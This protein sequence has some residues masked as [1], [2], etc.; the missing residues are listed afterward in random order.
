MPS[1][2]IIVV[3]VVAACSASPTIT[4]A[5]ALER[6][7]E[8]AKE[9]KIPIESRSPKIKN[10]DTSFRIVYPPP[11]G[12]RAGEWIFVVDKSTGEFTEI[13]IER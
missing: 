1:L 8:K 4:Q 11:Q 5:Q 2:M 6:V 12:A 10:T 7:A 9:L 3:F 13:R